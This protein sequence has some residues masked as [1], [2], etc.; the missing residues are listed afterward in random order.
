[1]A[2]RKARDKF[3]L[4]RHPNG[5]WAKKH[6]GQNHYFGTD[7][8]QALKRFAAEWDDI[9]AGRTP[10]PRR[11]EAATR[12]ADV[13]NAFLTNKRD[14]VKTGELT[15]AMWGQYFAT[16]DKLIDH[17]GRGRTLSDIRPEE[18]ASLRA[19]VAA[20]VGPVTLLGFVTKTRVV[21]KFAYDFGLIEHPV[22]YGNA[23]DRP[24]RK[25][26]R[27]NRASKPAKLFSAVDV[28]MLIDNADSQLA[29]MV[30]LGLNGAMGATDCSQLTRS[31]LAA[32]PGWLDYPRPKTGAMRRFPLWP[33][34]ISA[35]DRVRDA[36]PD[37]KDDAHADRV[38]LTR[39]GQPWVRYSGDETGKR[40]V[41]NAI[42]WQFGKLA[43]RVSVKGSFYALRHT[44]RTVADELPDQP[45]ISLIMGHTDSTMADNYRQRIADERLVAV[46]EHVRRWFLNGWEWPRGLPMHGRTIDF[47]DGRPLEED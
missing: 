26:L 20:G 19:K 37:P 21:F 35:L 36:R 11:D 17:F 12:L 5:Q 27:L 7:Q 44:F 22:K 6:R 25:T 34:T 41:M 33:E 45:A 23:F 29:A 2:T 28:R 18:F 14:R 1:M 24:S 32:R 15:E 16:C 46:I 8:G 30:L 10:R 43:E 4:W 47:D 3:P 42:A 9:R 31:M 39:T 38:F 40:S 13:V